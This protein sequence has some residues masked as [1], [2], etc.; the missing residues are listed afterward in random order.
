MANQ[1]VRIDLE[2][3]TFLPLVLIASGLAAMGG[4]IYIVWQISAGLSFGAGL[5]PLLIGA[6]IAFLTRQAL[7]GGVNHV[8]IDVAAGTFEIVNVK[9]R[10]MF[11][12]DQV[13]PVRVTPYKPANVRPYQPDFF[14]VELTGLPA[15]V[16]LDSPFEGPARRLH[17][18][19]E[20]L[21]ARHS[22][23]RVLMTTSIEGG[24][25]RGAP[26]ILAHLQHA[27][28]DHA[29]LDAALKALGNDPDPGIRT[30][31]VEARSALPARQ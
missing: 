31:A 4:L 17:E 6:P 28:A 19:L 14:K 15:G 21:I 25:F 18:Q 3:P 27:I 29:Q 11:P 7:K 8:L 16:L 2:S 9:R 22:V 13:G 10:L 23:R 1:R 5:V 20:R 24:A 30:R 12:L 26:E